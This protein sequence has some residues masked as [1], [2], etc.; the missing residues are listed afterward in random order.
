MAFFVRQLPDQRN[1]L[2]AAVL[3]QVVDY[4]T[5]LRLDEDDLG[6]L[7]GSGQFDAGFVDSLQDFR[8]TGD[9]DAVPEGAVVF[10][11]E[12]LLRITAPLREAQLIESR[13]IDL[14][15][16]QTMVASKAARCVIAAQGRKLVDFG[17]R[18]AHGAHAGLLSA[19]A[20]Y[21]AGFDGTATTLASAGWLPSLG[22]T[23][24]FPE[25]I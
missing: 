9:L 1:F 14:M 25:A 2:V 4:L 16:F 22:T 17:L 10:A 3:A 23:R 8:F 7:R 13:V 24:I 18:R 21:I 19:R 20:S 5:G 15:H 12:P 11:H 6:W